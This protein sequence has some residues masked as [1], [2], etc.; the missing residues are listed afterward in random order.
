M[1]F[2]SC[3]MHPVDAMRHRTNKEWNSRSLM[4]FLM[5]LKD[6][7]QCITELNNCVLQYIKAIY[8]ERKVTIFFRYLQVFMIKSLLYYLPPTV[9][10]A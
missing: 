3:R 6:L 7:C 2:F 8:F 9:Q 1:W 4:L 5:W 10:F